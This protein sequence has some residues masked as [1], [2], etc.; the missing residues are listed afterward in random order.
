MNSR[1]PPTW[2]EPEGWCWPPELTAYVKRIYERST[3]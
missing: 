2:P 1:T 3:S